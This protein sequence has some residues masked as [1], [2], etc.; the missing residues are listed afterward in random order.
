MK[1]YFQLVR[2]QFPL[3]IDKE[4]PL[5]D[6]HTADYMNIVDD[7]EILLLLLR[8]E[9]RDHTAAF[10]LGHAFQRAP[11]CQALCEFQ[12]HQLTTLLEHDRTTAE[13]NIALNLVSIL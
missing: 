5:Y 1:K 2:L 3:G 10:H 13:L 4:N 11:F 6:L 12:Q 8:R 7:D 9:D